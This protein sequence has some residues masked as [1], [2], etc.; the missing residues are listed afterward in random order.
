MN[1]IKL[2]S[3]YETLHKQASSMKMLIKSIEKQLTYY[4]LKDYNLSEMRLKYLEECL[5]GEKEMNAILTEENEMLKTKLSHNKDCA[6][7]QSEIASPKSAD[8]DFAQS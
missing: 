3:N 4:R 8:A 2:A 5:E 1:K 7:T 6:V